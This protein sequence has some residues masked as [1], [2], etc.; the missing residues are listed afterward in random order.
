MLNNDKN[1]N[2]SQSSSGKL[3]IINNSIFKSPQNIESYDNLYLEYLNGYYINNYIDK[4]PI[5]IKT[6]KLYCF[7]SK[8][9][10][11]LFFKNNIK[12]DSIL[13][14]CSKLKKSFIFDF[15]NNIDFFCINKD[16][17]LIELEYVDNIGSLYDFVNYNYYYKDPNIY[18]Y[19]IN[20]LFLIYYF[21]L[22]LK[23]KFTHY[24]LGSYNI[25]IKYTKQIKIIKCIDPLTK[26]EF[27]IKTHFIPI[28]ID[29]ATCFVSDLYEN[30][31]FKN[32]LCNSLS[33][34]SD[35]NKQKYCGN[36]SNFRFV[37]FNKIHNKKLFFRNSFYYSNSHDIY[38]LNTF[39]N[40][41]LLKI[42][43][44]NKYNNSRFYE[45]I[46]FIP[47][48]FANNNGIPP[49]E[50]SSISFNQYNI[51]YVYIELLKLIIHYTV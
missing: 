6:K 40:K 18:Y 42:F 41:E 34:T 21:L 49:S 30:N 25:L 33:C 22:S 11:T 3:K 10:K 16:L 37:D 50:I 32:A 35:A 2:I 12:D 44:I 20:I 46:K 13:N 27:N 29:Y 1:K 14:Y 45:F 43:K 5:F 47:K 4:Y 28:I 48:L 51:E 7:K 15:K 19:F 8:K 39:T 36:K 31:D 26:I 38:L 23:E 17:L 9:D 24:D